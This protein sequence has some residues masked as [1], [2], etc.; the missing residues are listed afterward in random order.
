MKTSLICTVLNEEKTINK[1]LQ[2]IFLQSELPDE[3]IIVDGG[4]VD[5]T[6]SEIS[7][8]QL[9]TSKKK[10]P[11]VKLLLK[12]GNRSVGRNEAIKNAMGDVILVSDAGCILDK[13]WVMYITKPFKD[14]TIDV[15]SGYYKPVTTNIFQKCLSTYTCVMPDKVDKENFLPSSRSVAFRKTVWEKVKGYP[16]DLDT[17]EDLVFDKKLKEAGS[18]FI[19]AEKAF[20]YW[21]QRHNLIQAFKQFFNYA[22]GDGL[23]KYFRPQTPY[24]FLRYILGFYFLY[25]GFAYKSILIF[26]LLAAALIAYIFWSIVKNYKYVHDKQAIFIL[27]VLQFTADIAV[28]LGTCTGIFKLILKY[29]Y[30]QWIIQNKILFLTILIY[31]FFNIATISWGVP[32]PSHPFAYHMDEWHS[33]QSLRSVIKSATAGVEGGAYGTIFFYF[34][35]ALYLIPFVL[36]GIIDP[37]AVKSSVENLIIQ[38]RLF[39]VLRLSTL[40]YGISA[41]VLFNYILKKY[42]TKNNLVGILIFIIS[43]LFIVSSNYFKYD[44]ANLFW[45]ILSMFILLLYSKKQTLKLFII[46]GIICALSISIKIASLPLAVIYVCSFFIFTD[47]FLKKLKY[48]FFGIISFFITL[49]LFGTPDIFSKFDTY[50]SLIFV[51]LN[52]VSSSVGNINLGLSWW[53]FLLIRE[54]PSIFGIFTISAFYFSFIFLFIYLILSIKSTNFKN[55][56]YL[57]FVFVFLTLFVLS[58]ITLNLGAGSN[59]ALVLLPI[60]AVFIVIVFDKLYKIKSF[61]KILLLI[62]LLGLILQVFQSFSWEYLKIQEDTRITSSKWILKNI[63]KDSVIG[64]ENVPIYQKLP[65]IILK[66]FYLKQYGINTKFNYNYEVISATNPSLP[67]IVVITNAQLENK[68]LKNSPKKTLLE[69]LNR[70]GYKKVKVFAPNLSFYDLFSDRIM[71]LITNIVPIPESI[72]V[73][74]K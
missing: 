45:I 1:F 22:K 36:V 50:K 40:L 5:N 21:P 12:K 69:R 27:P 14:K 3:I 34:T 39:E 73:Y 6:I 28:I 66:E 2:S 7:K 54:F 9:K 32:N 23:A 29:S 46:A 24:L 57:V 33:V 42:F 37:F 62:I 43:P 49:L 56:R 67:K 47:N 65:D 70:E 44:V 19:F 71:L 15:A 18:K 17:C 52:T 61:R 4:S 41:I 60:F 20:V 13:N 35:T 59:R 58:L 16:E 55:Y 53:L 30:K 11:A 38:Q 72:T 64:I 10:T 25:L 48:L 8:F 63:N 51:N 31:A 26:F 68:Y 74:S